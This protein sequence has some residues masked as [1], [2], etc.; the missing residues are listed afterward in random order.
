MMNQEY[1]V[2]LTPLFI[3]MRVLGLTSHTE[4]PTWRCPLMIYNIIIMIIM[5]SYSA[6]IVTEIQFTGLNVNFAFAIVHACYLA[7][8]GICSLF[9]FWMRKSF[10][11]L[12]KIV[13]QQIA[14]HDPNFQHA[15]R[16]HRMCKIMVGLTIFWAVI[17]VIITSAIHKKILKS[18]NGDVWNVA[19][20]IVHHYV[21]FLTQSALMSW[22]VFFAF[23]CYILATCVDEF[24]DDMYQDGIV[25]DHE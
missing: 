7:S 2:I 23:P 8:G 24:I 4:N 12:I 19:L 9:L 10:N 20:V 14:V 5:N 6:F 11:R 15:L 18:E 1:E 21:A 25:R 16:L 22:S 13:V 3:Y 17:A